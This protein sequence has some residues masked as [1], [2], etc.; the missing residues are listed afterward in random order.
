MSRPHSGASKG[1]PERAEDRR[2]VRI[3]SEPRAVGRRAGRRPLRWIAGAIALVIAVVVAA[4][5]LVNE[6]L[7]SR[8]ER[9]MNA[10]LKGYTVTIRGFDLHPLHFGVVLRDVTVAQQANPKPP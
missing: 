8:I 9:N 7:R 10:A 6:A 5:P 2:G 4:R 1:R 3:E